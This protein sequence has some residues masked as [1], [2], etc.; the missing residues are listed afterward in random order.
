MLHGLLF[1]FRLLNCI[2]LLTLWGFPP[3]ASGWGQDGHKLIC[4][5]AERELTE[6]ARNFVD[7]VSASGIHLDN[8][9]LS[10]PEA[11][12]WPDRAR[13]GDYQGSYEAHFINVPAHAAGIVLARDCAALDCILAGIQRSLV[14]LSRPASGER[15][16]GRKAAALR[17]LGHLIADLHQPLH[18]SHGE[19]RGGNG[20]KVTWFGKDTNLHRIWDSDILVRAGIRYPQEVNLL[21]AADLET[22]DD[23]IFRWME[24][25]LN[26][27]REKAYKGPDGRTVSSGDELGQQYFNHAR[28]V[29]INQLTKAGARLG[30]LLN[31]LAAGEAEAMIVELSLPESLST[32]GSTEKSKQAIKRSP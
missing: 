3:V 26:L 21:A 24:Q 9:T 32:G 12:L 13:Y 16:L 31:R 10:F 30:A 22:D 28:P 27:A 20:I 1:N 25:S 29:V 14:Y 7:S 18:V 4:A 2:L 6:E 15:E 23:D 11:C 19:D 5:L 8:E 17:F